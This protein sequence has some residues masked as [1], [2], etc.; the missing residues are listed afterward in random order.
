MR[1]LVFLAVLLAAEPAWETF[2]SK[3]AKY[4][5]AFPGKAQEKVFKLSM[6][7]VYTVEVPLGADCRLKA[8]SFETGLTEKDLKQEG[9]KDRYLDDARDQLVK[10]TKGKL[11]KESKIE[12]DGHPGRDFE[13]SL[14][15]GTAAVR[16]NIYL[17]DRWLYT[18]TVQ[19]K[20]EKV[21]KSAEADK[22]FKSFKL[23]K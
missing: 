11:G 12:V 9:F 5:V 7:T 21:I 13:I 2:T 15:K 16:A 20:G 23:T 1:S 8:Y 19:G 18:L 22:F 4:S 17:V 10:D 3:T 14:A 6:V